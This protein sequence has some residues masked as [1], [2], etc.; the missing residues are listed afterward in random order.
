MLIVS[1]DVS[2]LF[3]AAPFIAADLG[4][5]A[6]QQLWI[7]DVYGFVLA[8]LL[9]TMGALADRIGHRRLL[10]I[11]AIAFS[12]ASVAAAFSDTGNAS[13]RREHCWPSGRDAMPSTLAWS[14]TFSSTRATG[15]GGGD[16]E[17][18]S[19][20]VGGGSDHQRSAPRALL[21]GLGLPDQRAGDDGIAGRRT[22]P[23]PGGTGVTARRSVDVVSA[24]LASRCDPAGHR[25]HQS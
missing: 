14:A 22:V 7:F 17:R 5:T 11:G 25:G 4:A 9:L 15:T 3:F 21:V 24:V 20:V 16:V 12:T 18:C 13:S 8:G 1:M 19:P 2:V 10:M 6:E 23:A